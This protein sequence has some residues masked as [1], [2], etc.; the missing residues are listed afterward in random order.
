ML[1]N[2]F[3]PFIIPANL[4]LLPASPTT[5]VKWILSWLLTT[6]TAQYYKAGLSPGKRTPWRNVQAMHRTTRKY[7]LN[8][9]PPTTDAKELEKPR[10]PFTHS[11]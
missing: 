8:F 4:P 7:Q 11:F 3:K 9:C 6:R 2:D 1:K 5:E 10:Q